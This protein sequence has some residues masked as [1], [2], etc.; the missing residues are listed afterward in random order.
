[1]RIS[2]V[3][4]VQSQ[5]SQVNYV[6]NPSGFKNAL[7]ITTSSA[8]ITQDTSGAS[9]LLDGIASLICDASAQNGY[10]SWD[11]K[12][13]QEGDKTGNCEAKAVFKGDASLYKLQVY[14]GSNVVASSAVL[15]NATDWT[16]VSVNYPCGSTRTVRLTQTESGT[17]AAVNI[18]RV[19]WGRATNLGVANQNTDWVS[20]TPTFSNLTSSASSFW[21]RKN[22]ENIQISGSVTLSGGSGTY[23]ISIPSQFTINTSKTSGNVFGTAIYEDTGTG[24]HLGSPYPVN[25]TTIQFLGDDGAGVWNATNPAA[26]ASGD[27]ISMTIEVPIV[28]W[29]TQSVVNDNLAP[30]YIDATIDSTSSPDLGISNV[31]SATEITNANMTLKPRTGTA[32]VGIMCSSTNAATAPSTSNTT[33]AAGDESVGINFA[34]PKAGAYEACFFASHVMQADATEFIRT[35]FKLNETPTNAQTITTSGGAAQLSILGSVGTDQVATNP[36]GFCEI[37]NFTSV[38]TKGIRLMYE[39][40]VTGTPDASN[41]RISGSAG[42]NET[43]RWIVTPVTASSPMPLLTGS[44]TSQ[45]TGLERI[46]RAKLNCDSGSAITSQ[47]GSWLSSIGNISGGACSLTIASGIFSAAPTCTATPNQAIGTFTA[48]V[49]VTVTSATAATVGCTY[50]NTGSSTVN[51]CIASDFDIVCMGPRG[52]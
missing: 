3:D 31:G 42:N 44:V 39:Q 43:G 16:D 5:D 8:S 32:P 22:G 30:W 41:L 27:I 7:N 35:T 29:G 38:G 47:S 14:D 51:N 17:G 24:W 1:M 18:G 12:T 49:Q 33:C 13:I 46:E 50:L 11:S 26:V 36:F 4:V 21:W 15:S 48:G 25:S 40:S 19:Y 6:I 45:S 9:D 2:R 20:Y 34:I 23:G 37:F 52:N 28:G 10:C